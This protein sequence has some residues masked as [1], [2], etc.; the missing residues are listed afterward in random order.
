M[1]NATSKKAALK[2]EAAA[3]NEHRALEEEEL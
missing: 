3:L 1:A 2:A